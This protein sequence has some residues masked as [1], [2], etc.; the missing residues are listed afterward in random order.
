[1]VQHSFVYV[2]SGE[3][4]TPPRVGVCAEPAA[5]LATILIGW[6]RKGMQPSH[7]E[8]WAAPSTDGYKHKRVIAAALLKDGSNPKAVLREV[9][10]VEPEAVTI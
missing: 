2:L 5:R 9:C 3:G 7:Y 8:M 10:G 1:M 6:S 4:L